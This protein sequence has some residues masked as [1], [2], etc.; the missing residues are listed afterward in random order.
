M[1]ALPLA[2]WISEH[3]LD[4]HGVNIDFSHLT[5]IPLVCTALLFGVFKLVLEMPNKYAIGFT[6]I[7]GSIMCLVEM[8][9]GTHGGEGI[10]GFLGFSWHVFYIWFA[11]ALVIFMGVSAG[12]DTGEVPG[13]FRSFIEL[14]MEFV[15]DAIVRPIMG[16]NGDKYLPFLLSFFFIILTCNL[17]GLT[18]SSTTATGSIWVT[19]GLTLMSVLFYHGS[20]IAEFG[21]VQ[22]IVNFVPVHAPGK[23]LVAFIVYTIGLITINT[24]PAEPLFSTGALVGLIIVGLAVIGRAKAG[25]IALWLFMLVVE[26]VG[27]LAKPF[28]LAVR[29]FANMTGGH[30]VLYV[31]IGFGFVFKS[32]IIAAVVAVPASTAVMF[33][34][35]LVAGIQAY[36]FTMLTTVF[37]QA[38]IH[39][40]H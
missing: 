29:L 27:H 7:L 36:V 26:L 16:K 28:A 23:L 6:F 37:L 39:P 11:S 38:S 12:S 13:R 8:S 40:E 35:L 2:D 3:L 21:L 24:V 25:E 14:V 33:L 17:L 9:H 4:I 20:G 1:F 5:W 15:R 18:P 30:A 10:L 31:M 22:H 19:T 32:H 34:E